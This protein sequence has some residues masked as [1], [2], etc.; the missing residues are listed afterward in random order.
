MTQ[1][2]IL[3][4]LTLCV[5]SSMLLTS[6]WA[7][8]KKD[9]SK[10]HTGI[11]NGGELMQSSKIIGATVQDQQGQT[12]GKIHDLILLPDSGEIEFGLLS[13]S[14]PEQSGKFTAVPWELLRAKEGNVYMLNTEREKLL[15]AKMW[16][17][18]ATIDFS[19][20]D[21]GK[22]TCTH[23]GLEWD[24]QTS[25][26]G[27]VP[28]TEGVERGERD[29]DDLKFKRPQPDGRSTFPQLNPEEKER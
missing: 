6:A 20:A 4:T 25:V 15:S 9:K 10:H 1:K 23:Y 19:D 22:R 26:G 21:F 18:S 27:R 2:L 7:D 5:C 24:D 28:I 12:V 11:R 16:D 13:L 17:K 8:H 29:D 14:L 3:R